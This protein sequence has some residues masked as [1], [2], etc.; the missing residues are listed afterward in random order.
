MSPFINLDGAGWVVPRADDMSGQ[1]GFQ[2]NGTNNML[3]NQF[4]I[5]AA[6]SIRMSTIILCTFNTIAA[7]AT[8]M[9]I[10]YESYSR[11]KRN[12]R[13]FKFRYDWNCAYTWP[14]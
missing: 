5:A 10:L 11:A 14:S 6:R 12:N 1:S 8:A 4:K 9:G 3:L 2:T 13:Q 7:F